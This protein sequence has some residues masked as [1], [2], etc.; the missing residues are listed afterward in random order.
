VQGIRLRWSAGAGAVGLVMLAAALA[1]GCAASG[2]SGRPVGGATAQPSVTSAP[3]TFTPNPLTPTPTSQEQQLDGLVSQAIGSGP[4]QILT[5]YDAADGAADV[6]V[7]YGGT[8]PVQPADVAAAQERVKLV[9]YEAQRALWT[10][11][12]VR[13]R[14]VSVTV[15]GPVVGTYADV[16]TQAYGAAV[17]TAATE[18]RFAW[19]GLSPDAAWGAYDNVYLRP[20]FY[21]PD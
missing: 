16:E 10:G 20:S 14:R 18:A 13:L 19:N 9:C 6:S 21:D 2:G 5:T 7:T 4:Q 3:P 15:L 8:V 11:S 1:A 17:L 12:V